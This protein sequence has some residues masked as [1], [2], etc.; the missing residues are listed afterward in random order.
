MHCNQPSWLLVDSK[1]GKHTPD[2]FGDVRL[3]EEADDD[4]MLPRRKR[5]RRGK[6]KA[7]EVPVN[8]SEAKDGV[9]GSEVSATQTTSAGERLS[10]NKKR[11]LKKKRHKERM[12][13]LGLAPQASAVE[14]TYQPRED[15][16][17]EEDR[18]D[19]EEEELNDEQTADVLEFLK[20]TL[21]T[22]ISDRKSLVSTCKLFLK[23]VD[24]TELHVLT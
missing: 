16:E 10:R 5:R 8:E 3:G 7:S 13:S 17:E 24:F 21:Q 6:R 12:R 1:L 19:D 14:F 18:S 2:S 11:K 4:E 20:T 22:Y 23:P 15:A 9:T